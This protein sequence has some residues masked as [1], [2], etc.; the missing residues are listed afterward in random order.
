MALKFD[1]K[2]LEVA[3]QAAAP[4][5]MKAFVTMLEAMQ[6]EEAEEIQHE[7]Y[8]STAAVKTFKNPADFPMILAPN[9]VVAML[10]V[11]P[12][13]AYQLLNHHE[14][15]CN[16]LYGKLRVHKEDFLNWLASHNTTFGKMK[17]A[18]GDDE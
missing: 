12:S 17:G 10:G 11:K 4:V 6:P 14:C 8:V 18:S 1:A 2:M 15:P 7:G 9:D 5:M 3:A 16:P 13:K